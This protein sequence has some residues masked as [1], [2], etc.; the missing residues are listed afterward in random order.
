M[1][2]ARS[3][4]VPGIAIGSEPQFIDFGNGSDLYGSS[5]LIAQLQP[6]P[7]DTKADYGPSS[8]GRWHFQNPELKPGQDIAGEIKEWIYNDA[9]HLPEWLL[10]GTVNNLINGAVGIIVDHDRQENMDSLIPQGTTMDYLRGYAEHPEKYNGSIDSAQLD[11]GACTKAYET[12]GLGKYNLPASLI[13]AMIWNEIEHQKPFFDDTQT[14]L[15]KNNVDLGQTAS[16]GPG[17]MQIRRIEELIAAKD[18]R[19]GQLLYPQLQA[20]K[21]NPVQAACDPKTAPMFV[22]ALVVDEAHRVETFNRSHPE[23]KPI[24]INADTIAYLYNHDVVL[25][26]DQHAYRTLERW[27]QLHQKIFGTIPSHV[28]SIEMPTNSDVLNASRHVNNVRKSMQEIEKQ[29]H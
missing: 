15:A 9:S 5:Q 12:M 28:T 2:A 1:L 20:F 4:F 10:K 26:Q 13:P 16:V 22:A 6:N 19:T 29:I 14:L 23:N 3:M 18:E 25:D 17:Q 21:D 24:P 27:E 7:S 11:F 8:D